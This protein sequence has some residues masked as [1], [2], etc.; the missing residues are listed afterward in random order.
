MQ[1][2][3]AQIFILLKKII[4]EVEAIY[5][6]FLRTGKATTS[7]KALVAWKDV[8]TPKTAGGGVWFKWKFGTRLPYLSYFGTWL[9]KRISCG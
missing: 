9:V 5:R 3:W 2:F 4:K 8:C 1:T 7:K 6:V